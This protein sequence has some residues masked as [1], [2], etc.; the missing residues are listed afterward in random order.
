M[1]VAVGDVD[2]DGWPDLYVTHFGPNAL[3]RNRRDGTFTDIAA[4]AGVTVGGWSTAAA[5]G[6]YDGDG[7]LDLFVGRYLKFGPG[8]G[9]REL[10]EMNGIRIACPPRYYAGEEA[11]LYRNNGDATFTDVSH[12]TGV[13]NPQGKTLGALWWDPDGD[14]RLDLFVANDGVANSF[15]RNLGGGRFREEG[16]V[17]GLAFGANGNAEAS[18]GVA[19]GD[20]DRDGDLDLYVTNFQNETDALYRNDGLFF[21]YAT[22]HAR[23]AE[24]TLPFLSFG[25]A[26]LDYD[27]DSHLDLAI[28][29]GHVQDAIQRIDP[30][31]TFAQP[32]QLH[33][34]RGDGR[35]DPVGP[36]AGPAFTRPAVGRGLAVG[37]YDNDG[38]L[39]LAIHNN[40]GAAMLLRNEVGH[41]QAWIRLRL[42]GRAPN[43]LA[44]G[45]RVTVNGVRSGTQFAEIA[46]GSSYASTHDFR[47]H[48][49]LGDEVE[50][51]TVTVRWPDGRVSVHR[52]V[53]LRRESVLR[54]PAG[55]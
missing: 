35:F 20:Y 30:A 27:N 5:W 19:A 16:L 55:R 46:G 44:I 4:R 29:S 43:P 36:T 39:D 15:Y 18:M 1:G 10:C 13:R 38:D 42:E 3:Y 2:G 24:V 53:P 48:F 37:D 25:V 14:G 45:A 21:E 26:F 47:V 22:G 50:P 34:N 11:R 28:A 7:D 52:D 33:R 51:V 49:G 41:R 9:A 31:C 6:D 32:R 23:L 8:S 17:T 54:H 12:V 40:G